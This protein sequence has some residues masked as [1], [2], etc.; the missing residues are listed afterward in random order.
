M[1]V[2]GGGRGDGIAVFEIDA[3]GFNK[4][5]GQHIHNL[6]APLLKGTETVRLWPFFSNLC[7]CLCWIV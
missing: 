6:A 4:H 1:D 3:Q 7:F 2:Q 5:P